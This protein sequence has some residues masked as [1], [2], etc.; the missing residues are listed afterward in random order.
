MLF[1]K[2]KTI[3]YSKHIC[4]NDM[5]NDPKKDFATL[6]GKRSVEDLTHILNNEDSSVSNKSLTIPISQGESLASTIRASC[7]QLENPTPGDITNTNQGVSQ[8]IHDRNAPAL[9]EGNEN[10]AIYLKALALCINQEATVLTT[11]VKNSTAALNACKEMLDKISTMPNTDQKDTEMATLR[12]SVNGATS[13]SSLIN[14]LQ[15]QT[16]RIN[17]SATTV[18]LA[19][20]RKQVPIEKSALSKLLD[21][22]EGARERNKKAIERDHKKRAKPTTTSSWTPRKRGQSK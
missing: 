4:R 10:R 13:R 2:I 3:P 9:P 21:Q 1:C 12:T 6:I 16:Q 5:A 19:A 14:A 18:S 7:A 15:T 20:P 22:T 17:K 11:P 8:Y